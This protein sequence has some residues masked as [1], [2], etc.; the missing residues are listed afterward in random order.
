MFILELILFII[1][2]LAGAYSLRS[3]WMS[4]DKPA[5]LTA[6]GSMIF[7]TAAICSG[8]SCIASDGFWFDWDHFSFSEWT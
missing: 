2:I 8:W 6:D 7:G 5:E 3:W 4:S 1:S